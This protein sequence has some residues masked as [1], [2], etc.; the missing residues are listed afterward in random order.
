LWRAPDLGTITTRAQQLAPAI[1]ADA[2]RLL[3]WCASF[4]ALIALEIAAGS[5]S[6]PDQPIEPYLALAEART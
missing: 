1:R 5:S 3:D 6:S 2:E 4:G